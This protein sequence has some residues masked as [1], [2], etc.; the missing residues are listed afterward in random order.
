MN[1][2]NGKRRRIYMQEVGTRDGFQSEGTF[3]DTREKIALIDALSD[4][5][6]AKIEVTAFVS[7]QAIPALRDAEAVLRQIRRKPG[8]VYTALVPNVRGAERAI[9]ARADELN[10]VM[11]ASE[12]HNLSNLRMTRDQSFHGLK[13]V[14]ALAREAGLP[15]NI[16]LSCA[17][18]CPMEGDVPETT[19]LAWSQRF[20]EEA[21]AHGVTLCDTTGMAHPKQV[22]RLTARFVERWPDTELTLHFHNTR[23][24]GLANVLAAVDA[25]ADRFDASLGGIGGC[26]YAPGASGNVCSEEIVHALELMGYDT[27]IELGALIDAATR[28]PALI[29]HDIPSQIVKAGRRL[30]LHPLPTDFA[31]I[32]ERA[33]Q[34]DATASARN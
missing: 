15:V 11:S 21:S 28:L 32:R 6:L 4:T 24:M 2:W 8:V 34:R 12:S 14:A 23:G 20:I 19:V 27:G 30:D 18:G 7:P 3:V 29:G 9:D 33:L 5:G 26:P 31:A 13:Q 25:G 22:A 1:V 17:F 10:L 16:S